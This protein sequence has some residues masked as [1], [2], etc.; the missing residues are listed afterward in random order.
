[1][2][3]SGLPIITHM[4]KCWHDQLRI[5][6]KVVK[7]P[8]Y[9][10][11]SKII[12]V[13]RFIYFEA[14]ADHSLQVCNAPSPCPLGDH[15]VL[16][17]MLVINNSPE[18]PL[19]SVLTNIVNKSSI[20]S[21][22]P[23]KHMAAIDKNNSIFSSFFAIAYL[24]CLKTEEWVNNKKNEEWT[25]IRMNANK[26]LRGKRICLLCCDLVATGMWYLYLYS[27]LCNLLYLIW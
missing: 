21:H 27:A 6:S 8:H 12:F 17:A 18:L 14:N 9:L 7:I 15:A 1:M 4:L 22:K 2:P 16:I 11:P 24:R 25:E 26:N 5:W 20:C 3:E 10:K 19:Q 23:V 13:W